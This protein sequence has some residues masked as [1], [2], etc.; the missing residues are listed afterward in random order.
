MRKISTSTL[1]F[2]G[3]TVGLAL[4]MLFGKR[5]KEEE[6]RYDSSIIMSKI[7]HIQELATIKYNYAGVIGYK[8]AM[9][10]FKLNVPL[11]EK[12]FLLKYNGYL[13]AGVDFN[14]IK[15]DVHEDK[16]HVSM[17]RAK[18]FDVVIDENSVTVYNESENAFNPIK[19][20][21]YNQALSSEKETMRKDAVSQGILKDANRQAELIVRSLL[22]EMGFK[23]VDIT[24][25]IV[26]PDVR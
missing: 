26:I 4:F 10:L 8:D 25:E 11:T 7:V 18:I 1:F 2:M 13:K 3:T 24:L 5:A 17:P 23:D 19:I 16:V 21:D 22:Q 14:R 12:Y 9:K 15:V 20:S 6:V